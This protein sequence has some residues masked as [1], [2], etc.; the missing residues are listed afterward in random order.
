MRNHEFA[1]VRYRSMRD[2]LDVFLS[3]EGLEGLLDKFASVEQ[4]M[5]I[6]TKLPVFLFTIRVVAFLFTACGCLLACVSL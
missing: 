3:E 4:T 5:V 1:L 2:F 6:P